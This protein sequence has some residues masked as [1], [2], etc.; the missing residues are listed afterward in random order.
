MSTVRPD[1][2]GVA[3]STTSSTS[4]ALRKLDCDSLASSPKKMQAQNSVR[5]L[6]KKAYISSELKHIVDERTK[7][8]IPGGPKIQRYLASAMIPAVV[9]H[10]GKVKMPANLRTGDMDTPTGPPRRT[11]DSLADLSL[12]SGDVSVYTIKDAQKF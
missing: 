10:E 2:A 5:S 8:T 6:P 9:R 3:P 1:L 12:V 11:D 7:V 4:K